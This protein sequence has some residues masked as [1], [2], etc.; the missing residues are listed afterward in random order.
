MLRAYPGSV[1]VL[2]VAAFLLSPLVLAGGAAADSPTLF[3]TVGP[4]FSIRL[5]D[6]SGN[7]V[8]T[9]D[10]GTYTIQVEDKADVHNFHLTGPGVDQATDI[11]QTGTFTWTVT[12]A[13][14]SYH[15]QCDAHPTTIKGD[16]TVGG[17][18]QPPEAPPV[19][20]PPTTTPK[21]KPRLQLAAKVG[22][23]ARIAVT[24]L[25]VLQKTVPSGPATLVVSDRSAKDNFHLVG[26]GVNRATS[27]PGTGTVTWK[28]TLRRGL[29]TYR[30][31][32]RPGA[33][34][35][36]QGERARRRARRACGGRPAAPLSARPGP[37]RRRGRRPPA[38]SGAPSRPASEEL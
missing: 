34:R 31:D 33:A 26:P 15:Y 11:E 14:G 21:P 23:G 10:P 4:G 18:T 29:Y 22:P 20:P 27:R 13:A 6:A 32:A 8:K 12:F 25:G 36:V 24:R 16:L 9:L 17:S 28:L 19:S 7:P 2:L 1:R 38:A 30:S 35:L 37:P 3:G 5:A